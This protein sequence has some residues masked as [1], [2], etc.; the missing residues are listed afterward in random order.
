MPALLG[1][2]RAKRES[3]FSA[4]VSL[5]PGERRWEAAGH[6]FPCPSGLSYAGWF[7]RIVPEV[8]FGEGRGSIPGRHGGWECRSWGMWAHGAAW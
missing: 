7:L 5:P 1:W 4:P 8:G 3:L 2:C 6:M